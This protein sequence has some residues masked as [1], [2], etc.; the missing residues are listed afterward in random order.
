M[1]GQLDKSDELL[2][3]RYSLEPPERH[4]GMSYVVRAYDIK[5]RQHVA[6]K[7]NKVTSNPS[8]QKDSFNREYEALN[9]LCH[10][11]IVKMLEVETDANGD[12]FLVLEWV[13]KNLDDW[14]ADN[15]ALNWSI[16]YE[17]FG[18]PILSALEYAQ[19]QKWV[20]R[21]IKPKNI[22]VSEEAIP[23]I[24]DYGISKNLSGPTLVFQG[25][26]FYQD[27]T[28]GFSPK[29]SD[30]GQHQYHR[31]CFSFAAVAVFCLSGK[32]IV[33]DDDIQ[34]AVQ[35]V[36]I[37]SGIR[38]ILENCL[39]DDPKSRPASAGVLLSQLEN[40]HH[41]LEQKSLLKRKC[42][43]FVK[44]KIVEKIIRIFGLSDK[45]AVE[46]FILK[47]ISEDFGF[48]TYTDEE[49]IPATEEIHLYGINWKFECRPSG[50]KK[51]CLEIFEAYELQ[52]SD[53]AVRRDKSLKQQIEFQF[54]P[55]RNPSEAATQL[56]DLISKA[57]SHDKEI[58]ALENQERDQVLFQL[59]KDLLKDREELET[60]KE[61]AIEYHS[62]SFKDQ[63]TVLFTSDDVLL[64]EM[65]DEERTI[66]L[67]RDA[68][69]GVIRDVH[70]DQIEFKVTYGDALK[71]PPSGKLLINTVRER[72]AIEFQN[73]AIDSLIY[74]RAA[75]SRLKE[76]LLTPSVAK[77]P[78]PIADYKPADLS[79]DQEKIEIVENALGEFEMFAIEGPPGTGKTKLI[80]E[81]ITQN[82]K[83]N[84]N[85]RIL[86]SSQT[87]IALDN[88]LERVIEELPD[89]QLL[90][91]GR[92]DQQKISAK[93]RS[94][95][96]PEMAEK[97]AAKVKSKSYNAFTKWAD[98]VGVDK[99]AV[100]AGMKVESLIKVLEKIIFLNDE[101]K[102]LQADN[103][104]ILSDADKIKATE[105]DS[106]F[107]VLKGETQD[108]IAKKTTE[109]EKWKS[110]ENDIREELKNL[111]EDARGLSESNSLNDLIDWQKYLL[112]DN[113]LA[114]ECKNRLSLHEEWVLRV[115]K[116][117][118]FFPV[119]LNGAQVV[120]GTCVGIAGVK[121]TQTVQYDICIIDEASK[122]TPPEILIPL[123]KSKKWIVVGDPK[124]LP[125]FFEQIGETLRSRYNEQE[126]KA[127]VL[128][129]LVHAKQG[130]PK[131]CKRRLKN[132]YR[133]ITPIGNLI[134]NCFYDGQLNS[135]ISTHGLNLL[136]SFRHAVTWFSTVDNPERYER[137]AKSSFD[138]ILE[139]NI[140]V[141]MLDR[142]QFQAKSQKKTISVAVIAGYLG[143]VKLLT[144][145]I[146]KRKSNYENLS[147]EINSVDAFQGRQSD[148][149][150]YS[151]TRSN[152]R[153][154]LGFLKEKPRLNVALSRGKSALII[155]G[156]HLFCKQVG[157]ENP[158]KPVLDEIEG[159]PANYLLETFKVGDNNAG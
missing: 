27:R 108:L 120:G 75:N 110:L 129:R 73:H 116:S 30:S 138:N 78:V 93:M 72:R 57:R 148:V 136:P 24:S 101:L 14:I 88:V 43:L 6:I 100:M 128:D 4:G 74:N 125:P 10:P 67:G 71:I 18:R 37:P 118:D 95:L 8:R 158:Y 90:R 141:T 77:V 105:G 35:E 89:T 53:C 106:G 142:L 87:H 44:D 40:E 135:P 66:S 112:E 36:N 91:I 121:G 19:S 107:D 143:Q 109:L 45:K 70:F 54:D 81:I 92:D 33:T 103:E 20:H 41:R 58:Q 123:I 56:Q 124:Q 68:I 16:F 115:G 51:E 38:G 144:N 114:Q 150:I 29:E 152:Q 113:P 79:L 59:W 111:G 156:D 65:V 23:K 64:Q 126:I 39:S 83:R 132:Q 2:C 82:I 52:F 99:T 139:A 1:S 7:R 26:T 5:T 11:N 102:G 61:K 151:V 149:C 137:R 140:T 15:G 60:A 50:F 146:T 127:T 154:A 12:H 76:I 49:V 21:D 133:M 34:V 157:G 25:N 97:W 9:S 80:T 32:K 155:I 153:G 69:F 62:R 48:C 96:V 94:F 159:H 13:D 46:E 47:E 84:P 134:S 147:I 63:S 145:V 104:E 131:E 98:D 17:R 130:L 85:T 3:G 55:P 86:L 42:H 31:D 28:P 117:Q 22:L 119:L 122:A